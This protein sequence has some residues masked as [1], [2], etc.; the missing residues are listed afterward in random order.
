MALG[1][2]QPA[3]GR[4]Y[5]LSN[6]TVPSAEEAV[7]AKTFTFRMERARRRVGRRREGSDL[8]RSNRSGKTPAQR[9]SYYLQPVPVAEAFQHLKDARARRP[10]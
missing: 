2:A 7:T 4:F 1:A 8:L 5:A 9:W 3:A 10:V 6:S